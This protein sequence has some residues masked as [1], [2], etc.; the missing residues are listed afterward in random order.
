MV[1][2][3]IQAILLA[4]G[5]STRL[6]SGKTKLTEKICGQE[7]ILYATQ[8]LTDME[9]PSSIVVGYQKE[10][11]MPVITKKHADAFAFVHQEEQCGT[12]HAIACTKTS[13][14]KDAILI[15]NGDMP[16]LSQDIIHELHEKH[17]S[18][19]AAVS[20][21]I[22]H[23]NTPQTNLH[24]RVIE[25]DG[26]ISIDTNFTGDPQEHSFVH[27]GIYIFN[28]TFLEQHLDTILQHA[29]TEEYCLTDLI[30]IAAQEKCTISTVIAS[31]DMVR[32]IGTME[33]LWAVEQ[34][35]RSQIIR[36]WMEN[37]VRFS[38]PQNVHIEH[39]VTIGAGTIIGCAAHITKGS[40]IGTNCIINEF[41]SIEN[42]VL[43]N[44]V[45]INGHSIVKDSYV[46]A[47]A[48][49]GPFA[50][51]RE[52]T[53]LAPHAVIG[54][55]VEVKNSNIGSHTKAKH[56]T[57]LGD[58]DIGS[59]VN[60]GAGTI[61]CNYDSV[62]KH[63]TTIEDHVFI[64]SHSTLVAPVTIKKDSYT[65]AGSVITTDVPENSLAI[66]RTR[67]INKEGY[68]EKIREKLKRTDKKSGN[69]MAFMGAVKTHND[70]TFS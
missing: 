45:R 9:I 39:N 17:V 37:G 8:L 70:S 58:S 43:E 67:Q 19:N 64:G 11:V 28:R 10:D 49:V 65:A 22:A 25:K 61:T 63:K 57:F 23:N 30:R 18:T 53:T 41:A 56:L 2:K 15:M 29:D 55:F 5:K 6:K 46:G 59:H 48:I 47:H 68:A 7:I 62:N 14:H 26:A 60:I 44:N 3:N 52:K 4:A 1:E 69:G 40:R 21:I 66:A 50:H 13:W 54:N 24:G 31:F 33:E 20:F 16:L 27:T 34:I 42:S 51:I 32:D 38:V 35:K 36:Y 12:G